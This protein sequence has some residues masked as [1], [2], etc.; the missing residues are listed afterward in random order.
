MRRSFVFLTSTIFLFILSQPLRGLA[1]GEEAVVSTELSKSMAAEGRVVVCVQLEDTAA[2]NDSLRVRCEKYARCQELF[3]RSLVAGNYRLR[4]RYLYSPVVVLELVGAGA[5]ARLGKAPGVKRVEPDIEGGGGLLQSLQLTRTNRVHSFGIEGEGT[6]VAFLDTGIDENNENFDGAIIHQYHFMR[7][8][9]DE[10]EGAPDGHGHGSH[11]AGI[12]AS[13]GLS[14]PRGVAP[15]ASLVIV[16]VLDDENRGFASDWARGVEHVIELH[17]ADN[18]I[19][20]DVINMSLQT[21][22]EYAG[23]CD[24]ARLA[25]SN[26]C[27]VA[28][29]KGI[30]V[31]TCG[32]NNGSTTELT[33]PGCFSTT[34]TIGSVMDTPPLRLSSFTSRTADLSL[35]APGQPILSVGLNGG[36]RT[37]SGCSMAVPHVA[38][39]YCLL[40]QVDP[41]LSPDELDD[42]VAETGVDIFDEGTGLSF[43]L[44][45]AEAAV[46]RL[47]GNDCNENGRGDDLDIEPGGGSEDC[48][49]NGI[50]D[51]CDIASGFSL[52]ADG[53]GVAD[54]C[55]AIP[56]FHRGDTND[57]GLIDLADGVVVFAFLFLGAATPG[58]LDSVDADNDGQVEITDGIWILAYLFSGGSPPPSPGAP[59]GSCGPDTESPG[60][61]GNLGCESYS[62]CQ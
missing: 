48:N 52:D 56:V 31:L 12:L 55:S 19:R 47:T 27:G 44:I 39:L 57:D 46:A 33:M 25:F 37:R 3:L 51:E 50:P 9:D 15:A 11:V 54:E 8:G 5:L 13:R 42:L 30:S 62:N 49:G 38:G 20:V 61:V 45:D 1:G 7:S 28:R 32:G 41:A 4:Y 36:T 6:V 60:S 16:K 23:S 53:D 24:G 10:G 59:P 2:G 58:C 21:D 34:T 14:A 40:R 43:P 17:D 26:A 35:L 29:S 22:S 18:G